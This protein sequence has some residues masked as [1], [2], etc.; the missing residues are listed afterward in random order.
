M[1]DAVLVMTSLDCATFASHDR[2]LQIKLKF[3]PKPGKLETHHSSCSIAQTIG[4]VSIFFAI[5]ITLFV[6]FRDIV[7]NE[8]NGISNRLHDRE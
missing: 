4:V 8:V 7:A 1:Y 3:Q 6:F 2:A 5:L